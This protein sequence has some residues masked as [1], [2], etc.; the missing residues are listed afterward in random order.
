[1]PRLCSA[2]SENIAFRWFCFLSIDDKVF[3]HS[4]TSYF[5]ERIGNEG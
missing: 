2:V 3:D 1:M 4:T 5:I